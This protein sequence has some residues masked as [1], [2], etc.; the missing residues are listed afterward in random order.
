MHARAQAQSTVRRTD[1]SLNELALLDQS[2]YDLSFC[3]RAY[4]FPS[5]ISLGNAR[6]ICPPNGGYILSSRAYLLLN[7]LNSLS[8]LASRP[9]YVAF[10]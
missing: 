10:H 2:V 3:V 7:S 5:M 4:N 1:P 9:L 8:W 6:S